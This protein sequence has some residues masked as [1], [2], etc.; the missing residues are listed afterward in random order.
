MFKRCADG[1]EL[2]DKQIHELEYPGMIDERDLDW[3]GFDLVHIKTE[4]ELFSVPVFVSEE[5][6]LEDMFLFNE[7]VY[8]LQIGLVAFAIDN[9]NGLK[10]PQILGIELALL[11][12]EVIPRDFLTGHWPDN[13]RYN[14]L[15]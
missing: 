6:A 13:L 7:L 12:R 15:H 10:Q 11:R 4:E 14:F 3:I 5:Y 8:F 1:I 2:L 9:R